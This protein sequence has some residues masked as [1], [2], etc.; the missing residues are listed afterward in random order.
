MKKKKSVMTSYSA[1]KAI[2][3][4]L[5]TSLA[6][7]LD[8]KIKLKYFRDQTKIIYT[9]WGLLLVDHFLFSES[10][11]LNMDEEKCD[12]IRANIIVK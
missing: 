10:H 11:R 7:I 12:Q 5:M 9:L 1:I 3:Q 2:F 6:A 8:S 4:F